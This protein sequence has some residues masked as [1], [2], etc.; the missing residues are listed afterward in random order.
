MAD[1]T[2]AET[3]L[4]QS[5]PLGQFAVCGSSAN[6]LDP[7]NNP[8]NADTWEKDRRVR[9]DLIRW[10]CVNPR[11]K[12]LI[13]P[14]GIQLYGAK[15]LGVLDLSEIR[16]PFR[17]ALCK[18][19]ATEEI[20]L[21]AI[22]IPL[23]AFDGSWVGAI[24]A[25]GADVKGGITLRNGFQAE[26]EVRL[27][28]A[29]IGVDLD[30]GG[31]TFLNPSG[32]HPA[33]SGVALSADGASFGH[34][35]F[36]NRKFRAEGEVR[37]CR[38]RIGGDLDCSDA[39]FHNGRKA[40]G[41]ALNA[42]G[43]S[44]GNSIF[45]RRIRAEGQVRLPRARVAAEIECSGAKI[46]GAFSN[47]PL[48]AT[49]AL[50][51]EG[52]IIGGNVALND[53]LEIVG[54]ATLRGAQIAGQ[55]KCDG[56]SFQNRP[57]SSGPADT[58]ALDASLAA[59]GAGVFLGP[60]F[61]AD[62]E[63]RLQAARIGAILYC[64]HSTFSNPRRDG[65]AAS[66][67]ALTADRMTVNGRVSLGEGFCA[68]GEVFLIAARVEGDLDCGGGKF[69]SPPL[70]GTGRALSAHRVSVGGNVFIRAGLS[71]SGQVS[72]VGA[73]VQG[74]LEATGGTFRGELN[75]EAATVL[76]A[77]MISDIKEPRNLQLTF[78]N[79]SVS[80]LADDKASWPQPGALFL[81][82]FRYARFSGPAPKDAG[83]RLGWLALQASFVP[84]PYRQLAKVL[85]DEGESA[86]AVKV[87]HEMEHQ[88]R[89]RDKRWWRTYLVNPILRSTTGYGYYPARTFW[90][91][92]A[93]IL[94]GFG[95]YGFGY[96]CA[97]VTPTDKAAY[98][99]FK[100]HGEIPD[101]YERFHAFI[102]SVE[103]SLPFVKFGQVDEWRAD[104]RPQNLICHV[105]L[106]HFA[107]WIS[108]AGLLRWYRWLQ[109]L[110]GWIL[111]TLFIAGVTGIIRKD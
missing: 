18:C 64:D 87:L 9:T 19:R 22:E 108:F 77:L 80:A 13:D 106:G 55:L 23:L 70:T 78:T 8:A 84:Q 11:A 59:I 68:D 45:L 3:K 7:T 16:V 33:G 35:V 25:D 81:D 103:N 31:G 101:Q 15:L 56:A 32:N 94:I 82:G 93:V 27:Q 52:S 58:A 67:Y 95:L 109:V 92:A 34:G 111:G 63:V 76:G 2:P 12:A 110:S 41:I 107:V 51:I 105:P 104:P 36:L 60:R 50:N 30:C 37:F 49:A 79:A 91:L 102:Y 90:W 54:G 42:D 47:G 4:L 74:N 1:F 69:S 14:K 46:I 53:Q 71:S 24:K 66:G 65:V 39:I 57:S 26:G 89:A 73:S 28:R 98:S 83:S 72:F 86:G 88:V 85:H 5:A 100:K 97:V 21:R 62:G 44:V 40:A 99:L 20:L 48:G 10:L 17:I 61:A 38:A 96:H 6:D 29:K 43:L 75:L